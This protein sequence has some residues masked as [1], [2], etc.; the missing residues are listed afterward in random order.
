MKPTKYTVPIL[1]RLLKE[2][3]VRGHSGKRKAELIAML[4]DSDP[5][6]LL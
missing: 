1:K 4:Q 6:P 3:R 2:R 5:P